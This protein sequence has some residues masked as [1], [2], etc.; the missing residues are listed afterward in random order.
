MTDRLQ[1]ESKLVGAA[2]NGDQKAFERLYRLHEARVYA[3]CLRL[4]GD[5]HWAEDLLQEAFVRA[6]NKLG[7]FRGDAQFGTW[8]YRLT[9]NLVIS[10]LRRSKR[11]LEQELL[12][13]ERELYPAAPPGLER[14]LDKAI[15]QLP[16][17]ARTVLVLHSIE[18]YTHEEI[19][20]AMDIAVSTSKV[21]LHRA[22]KTLQQ[23]LNASVASGE[24]YL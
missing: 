9:A 4:C 6:W 23:W 19:A 18:G 7:G 5:R 21:Q 22:R 15:R 12:P 14:D 1:V 8:L 2:Q 3:L 16:D 24:A 11:N 20:S 13:D 17:G 10:Q